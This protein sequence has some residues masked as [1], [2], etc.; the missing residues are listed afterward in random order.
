MKELIVTGKTVDDAI[1]EGLKKLNLEEKDV[2][3]EIIEKERKG[4]FG[5]RA[6]EAKVK[7]IYEPKLVY[8]NEAKKMLKRVLELMGINATVSASLG[9]NKINLVAKGYEINRLLEK[10]GTSVDALHH[11]L[12]KMVC[13]KFTEKIELNLTCN[14][15]REK[16]PQE[17]RKLAQDIISKLN[18]N[19][20]SQIVIENLTPEERRNLKKFLAKYKNI[21]IRTKGRTYIADLVVSN[22]YKNHNKNNKK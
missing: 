13:K 8:M 19:N 9:R 17:I 5:F 14:S 12:T 16:K 6:R 3:I 4:I 1:Q 22:K 21:S 10:K 15:G 7:I 18:Q 2:N 11:L 20:T